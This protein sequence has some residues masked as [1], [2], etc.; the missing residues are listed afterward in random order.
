MLSL[1]VPWE[2]GQ[3][4]T[5]YLRDDTAAVYVLLLDQIEKKRNA[6]SNSFKWFGISKQITN[7]D[8]T[9]STLFQKDWI[10]PAS[11][12]QSRIAICALSKMGEIINTIGTSA[13]TSSWVCKTYRKVASSR[14]VY[15]SILNHFGV[16]TN[17]DAGSSEGLKIRVCQ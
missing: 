8:L 7:T 1:R 5:H 12:P 6:S 15:Y 13:R 9:K 16:A 14:P 17:W 11:N 10:Y 4:S 3:H 2:Y